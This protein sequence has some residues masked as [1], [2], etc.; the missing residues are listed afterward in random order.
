MESN[1]VHSVRLGDTTL[2]HGRVNGDRCLELITS[3]GTIQLEF[4]SK[5]MRN[6]WMDAF[7]ELQHV[8]L[9]SYAGSEASRELAGSVKDGYVHIPLV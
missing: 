2:F 9:Q 6:E 5:K 7:L 3:Q 4:D 8:N 1:M